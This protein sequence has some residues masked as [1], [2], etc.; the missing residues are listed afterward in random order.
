MCS[1]TTRGIWIDALCAMHESDRTGILIGSADQLARVLRCLPSDVPPALAELKST[2]AADVTERNGIVTLINRRMSREHKTRD[3]ARL[4]KERQR[5]TGDMSRDSHIP[6]SSSS[7]SSDDP[8]P[9]W[10]AEHFEQCPA[11]FQ[12]SPQFRSAY[13]DWMEHRAAKKGELTDVA[14]RRQREKLVAMGLTRAIK[15]LN[16][17]TE[18]SWQ[19]LFEPKDDGKSAGPRVTV[20]DERR[21]EQKRQAVRKTEHDI[22]A[23]ESAKKQMDLRM[24]GAKKVA[25]LKAAVLS[26]Q[27]DDML[28]AT[29]EKSD[30][31][32]GAILLDLVWAE[33]QIEKMGVK[34]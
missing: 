23:A 32:S 29:L 18:N 20:A 7:S 10:I 13:R 25:E 9:L 1:P 14:I 26:K 8:L 12:A 27:T 21:A 11:D 22:L 6:S 34:A 24:V 16:H 15:T 3:D 28:R 5:A 17:S 31:Y 2:G 30:P 33:L 4:R 19:G